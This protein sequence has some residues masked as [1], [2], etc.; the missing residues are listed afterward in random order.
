[1]E[2]AA[3][4][5]PDGTTVPSLTTAEMR[6]VDRV[7]VEDVGLDVVRMMEHAGRGLAE[8]VLDR[9]GDDRD[10]G[11]SATVTVVAGNGGNGGGGLACARHLANRETAVRVV[12][13][14]DPDE[15]DGV[16]AE[17]LRI[18]RAMDVP[19]TGPG[20]SNLQG[21]IV[22]A[23]IG[24]G[25]R[26]APRGAAETL[27]TDIAT[28]DAQVVSLDVPSGVDATTGERP[29]VAVDPDLTVTLALP[30]TGLAAVEG[31]VRLVDISIPSTVYD[32]LDLG[33]ERPFGHAFAVQL[34]EVGEGGDINDG[35]EPTSE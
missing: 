9:V 11:D 7:A 2:P 22:D 25:L 10:E 33:H 16:V 29:G 20:E 23:V 27:I 13:D 14:R 8:T 24:Y 30:K 26:E 35:G 12:L 4:R 21:T 3:Y 5:I 19:I 6:E 1:M 28:R 15:L 17:Q 18:L 34:V 32:R 31:D